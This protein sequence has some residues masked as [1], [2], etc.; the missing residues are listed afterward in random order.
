MANKTDASKLSSFS[1]IVNSRPTRVIDRE[2]TKGMDVIH[3]RRSWEGTE[4]RG[5]G[6]P[7]KCKW[8]TL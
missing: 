8:K 2:N 6:R 3:R 1:L 5:S 4:L 7:P